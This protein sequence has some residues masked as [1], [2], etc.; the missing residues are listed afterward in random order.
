MEK[1]RH[2]TGDIKIFVVKDK[3]YSFDL[4]P[5]TSCFVAKKYRIGGRKVQSHSKMCKN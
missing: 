1:V 4:E 2:V 5:V 3:I